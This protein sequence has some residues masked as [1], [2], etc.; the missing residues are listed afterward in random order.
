MNITARDARICFGYLQGPSTHQ[1]QAVMCVCVCVCLFLCACACVCVCFCV[2]V[3]LC[4]CVCVELMKR[5]SLCGTK[6]KQ[7]PARQQTFPPPLVPCCMMAS[8]FVLPHKADHDGER[9]GEG[10][11]HLVQSHADHVQAVGSARARPGGKHA[12]NGK[13][14]HYCHVHKE[15]RRQQQLGKGKRAGA[16]K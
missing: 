14:Q 1:A 10:P 15:T 4:V 8:P 12:M 13:Q 7:A 9:R 16:E 5:N 3:C 2:R 6:P 11:D